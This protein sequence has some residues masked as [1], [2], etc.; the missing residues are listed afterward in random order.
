M[1]GADPIGRRVLVDGFGGAGKSTFA[2]ALAAATG[3]PLI[4]LD[5]EFWR[6]GWIAPSEEEWRA[7]QRELLAGDEWIADGNYLETLDLRLERADTFVQ[8]DTPWWRCAARAVRRGIRRPAGAVMP[9]GCVDSALWRIRDE[10]R[11]AARACVDRGAQNR[12]ALELVERHG[13]H[14]RVYV[15]RTTQEADDLLRGLG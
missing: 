15:L 1:E 9:A 4:H 2:K 8:L 5:L 13:Q 7:Q 14:A 11:I 10:W 6:P 12:R 3:L